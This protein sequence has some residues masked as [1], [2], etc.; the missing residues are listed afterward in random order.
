MRTFPKPSKIER[1]DKNAD[2]YVK[3]EKD[4]EANQPVHLVNSPPAAYLG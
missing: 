1:M 3:Y 2:D 4:K